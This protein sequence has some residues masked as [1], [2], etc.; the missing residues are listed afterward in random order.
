MRVQGLKE[1]LIVKKKHK[2]HSKP[3]SLQQPQEYHGGSVF[4][5]PRKVREARDRQAAKE[6]EK[7]ELQ[8]QKAE[9]AELKKAAQ[10]CKE[11]IAQEKREAREAAKAVREKEKA[12]QA[13]EKER[14]KQARDA[15]KALQLSQKG[16]RKASRPPA[17]K[18]KRQKRVVDAVGSG[19]ASGAASPP[20]AVTTRRGRNVTLPS[21]Y[22]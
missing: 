18:S 9:A 22:E 21:R 15:A 10:L 16:K 4:W 17:Q 20:P 3:L 5:S 11:K 14:Q 1:A 12:E 19:E 2:K 7:K 13:A 6:R 8:L